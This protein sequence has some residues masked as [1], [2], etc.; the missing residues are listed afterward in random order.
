MPALANIAVND[1]APT[2]V[3]H[4]FSPV[5]TDGSRA[6]LANRVSGTTPKGMELLNIEVKQPAN[7][8]GAYKVI[9]TMYDPTEVTVSG[10]TSIDRA[11]SVKCELNFSQRST[12]QERTD[13]GAMLSNALAHAIVKDVISKLEPIY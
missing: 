12:A 5:T 11:N 1:G 10:I 6:Q 3:S 2:P 4:V 13:L 9:L 8:D 7:A